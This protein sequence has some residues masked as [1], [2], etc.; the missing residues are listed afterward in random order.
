MMEASWSLIII[1]ILASAHGHT[2]S[3][4]VYKATQEPTPLRRYCTKRRRRRD[5]MLT[6]SGWM[7]DMRHLLILKAETERIF[8]H[9]FTENSRQRAMKKLR[10][11]FWQ[12]KR[13]NWSTFR[14]GTCRACSFWLIKQPAHI[15]LTTRSI[16]RLIG[17][18]TGV[19]PVHV[20]LHTRQG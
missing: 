17:G 2:N 15:L 3:S 10:I 16:H 8:G 5:S 7:S 14:L 6:P 19:H 13:H 4:H 11:P 18:P 12:K 1:I 20:D 9:C